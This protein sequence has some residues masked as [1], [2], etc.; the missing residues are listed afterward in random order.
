MTTNDP[1]NRKIKIVGQNRR[2]TN[3][4][5]ALFEIGFSYDFVYDF[6]SAPT[7]PSPWRPL[8]YPQLM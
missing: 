3:F 2:E 5:K 7:A 8:S 1:Q 4:E 6:I